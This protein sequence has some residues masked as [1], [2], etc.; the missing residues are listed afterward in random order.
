ME[1]IGIGII[2][3]A[4]IAVGIILYTKLK[5][6]DVVASDAIGDVNASSANGKGALAEIHQVEELVIQMV[7]LV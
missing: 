7:V 3:V 4:V 6:K 1:Y 2:F 5:K